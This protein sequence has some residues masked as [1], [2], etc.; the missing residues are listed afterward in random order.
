VETFTVQTT[1]EYEITAIGA[2]GGNAAENLAAVGTGGA[3]AEVQGTFYLTAGETIEILVGGAGLNDYQPPGDLGGGAGGGGGTFVVLE[4]ATPAQ[5]VL[6]EAAGGGGGASDYYAGGS[7]ANG[8]DGQAGTAGTAGKSVDPSP[9]LDV[10]GTAGD[11]GSAGSGGGS[12]VGANNGNYVSGGGGGAGYSGDGDVIGDATNG[13][14]DPILTPA[15]SFLHLGAGG[16][17]PGDGSSGVNNGGFGGGGASDGFDGGGGYAAGGGGGS[18]VDGSATN[19]VETAGA[20]TGTEG[21]NGLVTLT[22]VSC[23]CRGTRIAGENGARAGNRRGQL[24]LAVLRLRLSARE[25]PRRRSEAMQSASGELG[26]FDVAPG[27]ASRLSTGSTTEGRWRG[28]DRSAS[29]SP[30]A[31]QKLGRPAATCITMTR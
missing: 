11:G 9:G 26:G 27:P 14:H 23:F 22:E 18:Y 2:N 8:V 1:G 29:S 10:F 28:S 7:A 20:N 21:G 25:R 6:L 24:P 19:V 12:G 3:G 31:V 30:R 5:N 15:Q 13:S 16:T 17:Y 4:G